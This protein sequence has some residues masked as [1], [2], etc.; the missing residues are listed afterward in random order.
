MKKKYVKN[1]FLSSCNK[2]FTKLYHGL[3]LYFICISL[4]YYGQFVY[5]ELRINQNVSLCNML[6]LRDYLIFVNSNIVY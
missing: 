2:R 6:R 4:D 3:L 5:N 1:I